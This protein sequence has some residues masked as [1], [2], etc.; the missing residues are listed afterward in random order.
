MRLYKLWPGMTLCN[1]PIRMYPV[2]IYNNENQ[3]IIFLRL[4]CFD[5]H[6]RDMRGLLPNYRVALNID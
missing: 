6:L 1:T 5:L 2:K 4:V 3:N